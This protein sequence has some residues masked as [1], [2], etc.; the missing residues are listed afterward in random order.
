MTVDNPEH[1]A[2][3]RRAGSCPPKTIKPEVREH[4][5]EMMRDL[6]DGKLKWLWI[7]VTNPFPITR[8]QQPLARRPRASRV[9]SVVVSDAYP[10]ISAKVSDLILPSAMISKRSGRYGNSER[11]TQLWR[12]A[13]SRAG[14]A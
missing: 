6:E 3:P 8:E 14:C 10:G 13:G 11:R 1:R 4:I 9:R 2:R 7:Q 5:T 12:Q